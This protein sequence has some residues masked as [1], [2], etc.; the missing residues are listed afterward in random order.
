MFK[1]Q[2]NREYYLSEVK[3]VLRFE[4]NFISKAIFIFLKLY[5]FLAD[6]DLWISLI[7]EKHGHNKILARTHS[8][9][10]YLIYEWLS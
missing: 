1:H 9:G 6:I 2:K 3:S 10:S 8:D 4:I 7:V 5:G